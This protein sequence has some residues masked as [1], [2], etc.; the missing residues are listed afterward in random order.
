MAFGRPG[1]SFAVLL[2]AGLSLATAEGQTGRRQPPLVNIPGRSYRTVDAAG[3]VVTRPVQA[4][5]GR[6]IVRVRPGVGAIECDAA[7]RRLG[8]RLHTFMPLFGMAVIELGETRSLAMAES[9]F[10]SAPEFTS[11]GPDLLM[12]PAA[13]PSDDRYPPALSY[14]FTVLPSSKLNRNKHRTPANLPSGGPENRM[15]GDFAL[16]KLGFIW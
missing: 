13:I 1:G 15:R 12:Y 14:R 2:A 3:R 7:A 8:G 10:A 6:L 9:T 4:V 16:R 11:A 5:A